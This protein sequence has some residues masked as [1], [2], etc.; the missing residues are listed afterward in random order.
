MPHEERTE[1]ELRRAIL[2]NA[3]VLFPSVTPQAFDFDIV[4]AT[5]PRLPDKKSKIETPPWQYAILVRQDRRTGES[6]ALLKG[7]AW[8]TG[9][10]WSHA[11]RGLL[12]N[13]ASAVHKKFAKVAL[14]G[15]AG[16]EELPEYSPVVGEPS[17]PVGEKG[18]WSGDVR[19]C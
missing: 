8:S 4:F 19:G 11:L 2:A 16:V 12:D 10:P 1:D 15:V 14:P 18:G 6:Q 5:Y 3:T 7:T 13:T 17:T 9:V